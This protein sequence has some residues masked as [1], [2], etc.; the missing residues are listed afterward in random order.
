[1]QHQVVSPDHL[2][3]TQAALRF[4]SLSVL[5]C[6]SQLLQAKPC[7]VPF[8][9]A[10]CVYLLIRGLCYFWARTCEWRMEERIQLLLARA[11]RAQSGLLATLQLQLLLDNRAGH[12]DV[13]LENVFNR[14]EGLCQGH[15]EM[16][17]SVG[18]VVAAACRLGSSRLIL[19]DAGSKRLYMRLSLNVPVDDL[20]HVL[21]HADSITWL[22]NLD[23]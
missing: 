7:E 1:M 16:S 22:Q 9:K 6:I 14:L 21:K 12:T 23:F 10:L 15:S 3:H 4:L 8:R 11:L 17:V 2:Q 18:D 20:S 19:C 13:M 5:C